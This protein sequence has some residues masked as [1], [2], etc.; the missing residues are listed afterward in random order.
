MNFSKLFKGAVAIAALTSNA[1]AQSVPADFDIS[2]I[3]AAGPPPTPTIASNVAAQ[4]VVYNA[5]A[6]EASAAAE[7]SAA[8]QDSAATKVKRAACDPQLQGAGPVPCPD[9]DQAFVSYAAFAS[10]ASAAPTPSGYVNTFKNLKAMN[11]ALGYMGYTLMDT[12]DVPLCS[13]KCDKINGCAAFNVAFERSPSLDPSPSGGACEQPATTTLIKCVF[14]GGPVTAANA[15]NDGQWRNN[16]HVVIA[17]SNGYVNQTVDYCQ[18]YNAPNF[19]GGRALAAP[20]DCNGQSS[21]VGTQYW[22]DGHP[23]DSRRCSAAC[24][25][26]T[27]AN[28]NAPCRFFN[29]YVISRNGQSYGQYCAMYKQQI[30]DSYATLSQVQYNGATYSVSYSY[31]FA[32]AQNNGLPCVASPITSCSSPGQCGTYRQCNPGA[33]CYCGY[34]TANNVACFQGAYCSSQTCS[35]NAQCGSGYIC[36]SANSCCGFSICVPNTVCA[37]GLNARHIFRRGAEKRDQVQ[38]LSAVHVPDG[39]S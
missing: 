20:N 35:T 22:N 33:N 12:Y 26:Q 27:N 21:L 24:D 2:A 15:V 5:N 18:G 7:Q 36:L 11:N 13:S 19:Y 17:G 37:N 32:N 4:T 38:G 31:S 25:A 30:D 1:F 9:T 10:A 34:D 23:F 14:W 8:A 28:P 6:V 3:A 39:G 29:T 16:Y